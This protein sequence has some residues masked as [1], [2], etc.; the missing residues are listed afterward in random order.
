MLKINA[1]NRVSGLEI[2]KT[3]ESKNKRFDIWV[4]RVI[5]YADLQANIDFS[6]KVYESTGVRPFTDYEFT[7][8]A[9]K[10]IC[11]LEKNQ[12]GKQMKSKVL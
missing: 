3:I 11:L 5:E 6:T 8:D 2:H 12:K 4:K 9:A 1:N 10:E 7:I